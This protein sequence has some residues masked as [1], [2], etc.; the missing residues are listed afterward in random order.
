MAAETDG[1]TKHLIPFAYI[2][3]LI[4]PLA[5]PMFSLALFREGENTHAYAVAVLAVVWA[6]ILFLVI[7]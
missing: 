3:T 2:V 1:R 6:A 7:L 4:V 5:A